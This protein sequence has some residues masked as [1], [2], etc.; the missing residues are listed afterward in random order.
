MH[1][2]IVRYHFHHATIS[3]LVKVYEPRREET[4]LGLG[5][6]PTQTGL[7]SA[8]KWLKT[9]DMYIRCSLFVMINITSLFSR[10]SL[11]YKFSF[12]LIKP[13]MQYMYKRSTFNTIRWYHTKP[14]CTQL[15]HAVCYIIHSVN[16]C[17]FTNRLSRK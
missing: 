1:L 14:C 10:K 4:C 8:R 11:F 9:S 16:C 5:P 17:S 7:Y 12:I 2:L 6:G 3:V 13:R 15:S